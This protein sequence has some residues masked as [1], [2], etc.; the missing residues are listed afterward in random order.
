MR[1]A[2]GMGALACVLLLAGQCFATP[3]SFETF[4]VDNNYYGEGA[5]ITANGGLYS[6]STFAL[7]QADV[8]WWEVWNWYDSAL[9]RGGVNPFWWGVR[10][11]GPDGGY[12]DV[13]VNSALSLVYWT[14]AFP[15][16]LMPTDTTVI[17]DT[18]ALLSAF[19]C[20]GF[21]CD[22]A[23][24][25]LN[26]AY[27]ELSHSVLWWGDDAATLSHTMS[28]NLGKLPVNNYDY[29]WDGYYILFLGSL[30]TYAWVDENPFGTGIAWS[31]SDWE[32]SLSSVNTSPEPTSLALFGTGV[33]ALMGVLRSKISP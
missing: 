20:S 22:Y 8:A 5:T 7:C 32:I 13:S 25:L 23:H 26:Q 16:N 3:F 33:L 14:F 31:L 27:F 15:S 10:L 1:N 11:R 2:I 18:S 30:D 28:F 6:A 4:H 9:D 21:T 17:A 19:L 29:A 12:G 24:P